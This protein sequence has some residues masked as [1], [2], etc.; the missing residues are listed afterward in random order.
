MR[1]ADL[2]SEVSSLRLDPSVVAIFLFGQRKFYPTKFS[3]LVP[4][5]TS[6]IP[7][8][9]SPISTGQAGSTAIWIFPT[10]T[11]RSAFGPIPTYAKRPPSLIRLQ[12]NLKIE[13]CQI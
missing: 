6:C 7:C 11:G 8:P 3:A 10:R 9:V 13:Q 4:I 5:S 1:M 2:V 12:V